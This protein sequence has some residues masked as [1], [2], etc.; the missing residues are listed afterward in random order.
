MT[1]ATLAEIRGALLNIYFDLHT[2]N[3]EDILHGQD[4]SLRPCFSRLDRLAALEVKPEVLEKIV[5]SSELTPVLSLISRLR[6]IYGLRLEIE[7]AHALLASPDPWAK[8]REFTFYTNYLQLAAMEHQGAGLKPKNRIIFLGSGPLPLSL[9]LLCSQYGLKGIGIERE[10]SS[11]ELSRQVVEHLGLEHQISIMRGDHFSLPLKE[12]TQ[13][14]M[15]AAMARPKAEIFQHLTKILPTG[16]LVSYRLYEK[17]LRRL[18]DQEEEAFVPPPEFS[19]YCRMR[20][21]PPVNNT[22]V[23]VKR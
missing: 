23:V 2:L 18:L 6:N 22:V 7:Q 10:T 19:A 3:D 9:I 16:S 5:K 12:E 20:P 14:L 8:L 17:G 11:V 1:Q 21:Q 4:A 15:V 13:L